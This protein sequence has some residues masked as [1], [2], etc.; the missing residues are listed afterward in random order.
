MLTKEVK[1]QRILKL[2]G[3]LFLVAL[4]T[5]SVVNLHLSR[6]ATAAPI[7]NYTGPT[8]R[9]PWLYGS[10]S[11]SQSYNCG[12]DWDHHGKDQFAIDFGFG[13]GKQVQLTAVF[14]G[15]VHFGS[16]DNNGYGN[17]L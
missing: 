16:F 15:T 11:I 14:S 13:P 9:L 5:I 4:V 12:S 6:P 10:H 3:F 2:C 8:L 7:T 1:R 17:S